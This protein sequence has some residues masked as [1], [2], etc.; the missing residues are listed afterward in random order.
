[1]ETHSGQIALR[2]NR[3]P[4]V[5]VSQ[6]KDAA[7]VVLTRCRKVYVKSLR[8]HHG[9]VGEILIGA[10]L[11]FHKRS[12]T[13]VGALLVAHDRHDFPFPLTDPNGWGPK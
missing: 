13:A 11:A 4:L 3:K 12:V 2:Q 10:G 7:T 6:N 9:L 8:I 5:R 1:M